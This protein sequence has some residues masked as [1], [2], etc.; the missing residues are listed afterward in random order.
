MDE[1][2]NT[3]TESGR[4]EHE[5]GIRNYKN[6]VLIPI[7]ERLLPQGKEGWRQVTTLAGYVALV[8]SLG[9]RDT[10]TTH[11]MSATPQKCRYNMS[12]T[13]SSVSQPLRRRHVG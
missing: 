13:T 7:I 2:S 4:H 12:A 6:D 3:K 10:V 11:D 9:G 5:A 8:V 1:F